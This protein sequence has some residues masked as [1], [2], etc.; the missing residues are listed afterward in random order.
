MSLSL[1]N[2][3]R[4]GNFNTLNELTLISKKKLKNKIEG[5][6]KIRLEELIIIMKK[7]GLKFAD[8]D[9]S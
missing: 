5:F 3:L 9:K 4:K 7:H 1:R 2:S 6:G 8:I